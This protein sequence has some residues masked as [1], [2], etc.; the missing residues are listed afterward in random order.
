MN[1]NTRTLVVLCVALV[2]A[3]LATLAVY[4]AVKAMPVREVELAMSP[5]VLAARDLPSG[6]ILTR[7]DVTLTEWP[8]TSRVGSSFGSADAVLGRG[9][10][11]AVSANEPFTEQKLAPP[12]AGAGLPPTIPPGMRAMS[13]K[14]D[15][16]IGVAGFVG[17]GTRV[18]LVATLRAG[19]NSRE[20]SSRIILSNVLVLMSGTRLEQE[21]TTP[22]TRPAPS[23]V[24][25]LAVTPTDAEMIALAASE[26]RITLALRN[27]LDV[28]STE[29]AGVN[30]STLL[31]AGAPLP[32]VV[33]KPARKT[34]ARAPEPT[35][36]PP[37]PPVEKPYTVQAIRAAKETTE[38]VAD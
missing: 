16:V 32:V 13:V 22:A 26:G 8:A 5:I 2:T 15:D 34:V 25:T 23:S 38:K 37:P 35:P 30:V 9:L 17:P 29:S 10:V 6:T 1:R 20:S 31:R 19:S 27:P 36:P 33:E 12:G 3:G 21:R 24:V 14:V 18:D 4:Q 7:D 11:A 28:A